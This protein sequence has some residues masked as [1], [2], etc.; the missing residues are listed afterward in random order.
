MRGFFLQTDTSNETVSQSSTKL[1]NVKAV[2]RVTY[3]R[4]RDPRQRPR[5]GASALPLPRV[6]MLPAPNLAR[7]SSESNLKDMTNEGR[8]ADVQKVRRLVLQVRLH[9]CIES[10]YL[11]VLTL[12]LIDLY[13][14]ESFERLETSCLNKIADHICILHIHLNRS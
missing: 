11:V 14:L 2:T 12:F 7:I 8:P 10:F 3:H 6:G 13:F 5:T 9:C 4:S 1:E